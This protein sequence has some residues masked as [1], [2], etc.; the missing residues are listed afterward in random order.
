[1]NAVYMPE[2]Q[3]N[4]ELCYPAQDGQFEALYSAINGTPRLGTG[5]SP[6]MRLIKRD[7]AKRLADSDS[8]WL[9]AFAL[10]FRSGVVDRVEPLLGPFGEFLPL[11]CDDADL[12]VFNPTCV[13]DALDAE[14]ADVARFDDGRIMRVRRYAFRPDVVEGVDIFKLTGLRV[15]PTFLSQRV[16][17]ALRT[18]GLRG[19][20]FIKVWSG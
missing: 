3:A 11:E 16:A 20:D 15:S 4:V 2:G 6:R 9:G 10:I 14:S 19:L 8:P 7:G 1:M 17:D 13:L 12:R 18:S 5:R